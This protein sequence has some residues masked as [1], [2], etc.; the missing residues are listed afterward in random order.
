MQVRDLLR[1]LSE[2]LMARQSMQ[3]LVWQQ[4]GGMIYGKGK[5]RKGGKL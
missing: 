1:A 3:G 4:K 2:K 5:A